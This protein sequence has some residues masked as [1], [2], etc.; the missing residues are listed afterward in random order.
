MLFDQITGDLAKRIT[1]LQGE[2]RREEERSEEGGGGGV[3][4]GQGYRKEGLSSAK[5]EAVEKCWP[6]WRWSEEARGGVEEERRGEGD[7][8]H[9]FAWGDE[10]IHHHPLGL[11]SAWRWL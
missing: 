1:V 9:S 2:E 4:V 3:V 6:T 11:V 5:S 8:G 10:L 7:P